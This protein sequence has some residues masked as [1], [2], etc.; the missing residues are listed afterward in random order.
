MKVLQINSCNFGSTGGI[1]LGIAKVGK[2][3]GNDMYTAFAKSRSNSKKHL[4]SSIEIGGIISRNLHLILSK[5]TGYN[6]CFS[7]IATWHFLKKVKKLQPDIIHLHNLHNCYINLGMLLSYIKK[8]NIKTVWT[9]HDCWAFTGQCPHFTIAK[10]DKWKSHCRECG[11]YKCYPSSMVDRTK[12]MYK[13]KKK[14][15]TGVKNMTIVTPSKWLADL[16]GQSFL[17]E[18]DV[19]VINNGINLQVFKPTKSNFREKYDL[20]N[21]HII[22][23]VA[24]YWT[25]RKGMDVFLKLAEKL[26]DS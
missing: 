3:S 17:K 10:C 19:K 5:L 2:N 21:K 13:L 7:V 23:G 20:E 8:H 6:G 11:Q 4:E 12:I 22:L 25:K 24:M 9:L 14:W 18:Y 1:M 16:V 26:D 15:F